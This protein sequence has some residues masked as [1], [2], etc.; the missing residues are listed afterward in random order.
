MWYCEKLS[1]KPSPLQTINCPVLKENVTAIPNS[2]SLQYDLS[3]RRNWAIYR[4]KPVVTSGRHCCIT[5]SHWQLFLMPEAGCEG[6]NT[7]E[8]TE[9]KEFANHYSLLEAWNFMTL[10][11]LYSWQHTNAIICHVLLVETAQALGP[12]G[13]SFSIPFSKRYSNNYLYAN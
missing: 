1:S 8:P 4:D 3:I 6:N 11:F 5:P 13:D 12:V 7:C 2:F 9:K 10:V